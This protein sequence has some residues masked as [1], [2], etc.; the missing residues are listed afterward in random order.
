M[1][2][3]LFLIIS[4]FIGRTPP[5]V[6]LAIIDYSDPSP[7]DMVGSWEM[8]SSIRYLLNSC[9]GFIRNII[10]F[11][12]RVV[13]AMYGAILLVVCIHLLFFSLEGIS[14]KVKVLACLGL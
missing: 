7:E 3:H 14:V 8:V 4:S 13:H 12:M 5:L 11:L 2:V 6:R 9:T 10:N 1:C